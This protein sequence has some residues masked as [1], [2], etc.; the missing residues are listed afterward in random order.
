M[1]PATWPARPAQ[2]PPCP[3][4]VRGRGNCYGPLRLH[5][6]P[7][8]PETDDSGGPMSLRV[9][10][11]TQIYAGMKPLWRLLRVVIATLGHTAYVAFAVRREPPARRPHFRAHRQQIGCRVLCRILGVDVSVEGS[12]PAEG[13]VMAVS[14]HM[15]VLDPLVIASILPVACVGKAELADWPVIGWVTREMGVIPVD[16]DR[17]TQSGGLVREVQSRLLAGVPVLVFPEGTTN[18]SPDLLP[19][20]T[21]AFAAVAGMSQASVLP[22]FLVPTRIDGVPATPE[23]RRRVTWAGGGQSFLSNAWQLLSLRRV[24]FTVR[25]GHPVSTTDRDRKELARL[26]H[27]EV[28]KLRGADAGSDGAPVAAGVGRP[29][30]P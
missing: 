30:S 29:H 13:S 15:G 27:G 21:G 7:A 18:E 28:S 9:G 20:K 8:L 5:G 6:S 23:S 11:F 17:P 16:R 26:L 24:H 1:Q 25:I 12:I 10:P 19:F 14:N 22:L 4:R 3:Q 2:L